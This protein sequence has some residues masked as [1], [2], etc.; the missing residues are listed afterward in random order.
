VGWSAWRN[1]RGF[2]RPGAQKSARHDLLAFLG[3]WIHVLSGLEQREVFG[4]KCFLQFV[5]LLVQIL[6]F[7]A[8]FLLI[9]LIELITEIIDLAIGLGLSLITGY[10]AS[11]LLCQFGRMP[12]RPSIVILGN[13]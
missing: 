12:G 2:S 7:L 9:S 5:Y 8:L 11:D 13:R 6:G 4:A 1:R 10:D 3:I